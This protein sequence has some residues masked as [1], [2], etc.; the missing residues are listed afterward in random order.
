M[1]KVFLNEKLIRIGGRT[2]ITLNKPTYFFEDHCNVEE[3][4]KWFIA[5]LKGT[6]NEAFLVHSDPA[7]FFEFFQSAFI[8]IQAA[9]GVV[10]RKNKLMFIFRNGKW[11][12]PKGKIDQGETAREAALREVEEECGISGH[13]IVKRLP[14]TYHMYISPYK[15]SIGE[16]VFKETFWFEMKYTGLEIGT[17]QQEEGITQIKWFSKKQLGEVW[18]NTYENL[19]SVILPYRD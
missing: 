12:L 2:N 13:T 6:E 4:K 5:F 18:A 17:P 11:D 3:V 9:G 19:K 10:T 15:K 1:Y 8:C 7:D 16:W 14:P